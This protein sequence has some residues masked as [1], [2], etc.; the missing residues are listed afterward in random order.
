M[1]LSYISITGLPIVL[2]CNL[3][4]C[5]FP[6][7]VY[8]ISQKNKYRHIL[9]LFSK[10]YS[11]VQSITNPGMQWAFSIYWLNEAE[12]AF[13]YFSQLYCFSL[14]SWGLLLFRIRTYLTLSSDFATYLASCLSCHCARL[15]YCDQSTWP[16]DL[17]HCLMMT[18]RSNQ[19]YTH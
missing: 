9:S 4:K 8:N 5:M 12:L 1:C 15:P 19:T 17:F 7:T 16:S 6:L 18:N 13:A 3:F 14:I 10:D 2:C 11:N